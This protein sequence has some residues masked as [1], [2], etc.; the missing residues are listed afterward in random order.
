[1]FID[2]KDAAIQLA[3]ELKRYMD[4][5]VVVLGIPRGGAETGYY[6]ARYL[7]AGF[8]ILISR[9]LG[10]PMNPEF[11]V[12]AIAEDGSVYLSEI[13]LIELSKET[14]DALAEAQKK[15]IQRRIDIL[16][17]GEP[18]PPLKGKTVILVDD[19]IATGATL[20]AAIRMCR[21]IGVGKLVVAAPVSAIETKRELENEADEVVILETPALYRAVSQVYEH[22]Y[23]LT[24]S[25]AWEFTERWKR[26]RTSIK[27]VQGK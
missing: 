23:N 4:K 25:E 6:V 7:N 5:D 12:G 26:E 27:N 19:G 10:H 15:E 21:N 22:F 8:S 18:L 20:Y 3:N 9:K 1:M 11:A 16:R 2:R 14:V 13:G 24:D 17:K